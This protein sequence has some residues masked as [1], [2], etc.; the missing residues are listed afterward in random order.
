MRDTMKALALFGVPPEKCWPYD[1]AK[2]ND[3]PSYFCFSSAQNYQAI[4]YYRIDPP[5]TPAVTVLKNV[6]I[7]LAD[8]FRSLVKVEFVDSDLFK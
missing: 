6:K 5:N 2:F 8:D 3:D 4:N 1:V 7:S